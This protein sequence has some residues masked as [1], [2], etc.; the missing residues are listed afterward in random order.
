MGAILL[1]GGA[2]ELASFLP[3]GAFAELQRDLGV[4]HGAAGLL[5]VAFAVGSLLVSPLSVLVDHHDRRLPA[6]GGVAG[7]AAS[8]LLMAAAPSLPLVLA[9]AL[10]LGASSDLM[11]GACEVAL[12][13]HGDDDLHR[14][15]SRSNFLASVGDLAGPALFVAVAAFGGS[16][17]AALLAGAALMAAYALLLATVPFPPRAVEASV[18][19]G[20]GGRAGVPWRDGLRLLRDPTLWWL[21]AASALFSQLDEAYFGFA[22]AF[23]AGHRH[24]G[25]AS[26][27]VVA[28]GLVVGGLVT[29]ARLSRRPAGPAAM[30][31]AA[32]V[33]T[34]SAVLVALVPGPIA[35]AF[36]TTA[37]GA[38]V[39]VF[40]VGLQSRQLRHTEGRV[41][42][43]T[44][45]V[46]LLEQPGVLVPVA[47]GALADRLGLQSAMLA[48]AVVPALLVVLSGRLRGPALA[49][50]APPPEEPS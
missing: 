42:A 11:V 22:S 2:D 15:V 13:D 5:F 19:S 35:L 9:A 16:W 25:P 30:P 12:A 27:T 18:A 29:Y 38:A 33:L 46:G 20:L 3:V 36:V 41:G 26:A 8:L 39:A 31:R 24:L 28:S 1:V 45:L 6:V 4:D 50:P 48:Y 40:W 7:Y 17:R 14:H 37:F 10:L 49:R 32:A 47:V 43:V 44:T 34:L 23:L 21:A